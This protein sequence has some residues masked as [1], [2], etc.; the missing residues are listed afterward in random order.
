MLAIAS[1]RFDTGNALLGAER[2]QASRKGPGYVAQMFV[3]ESQIVAM[4]P[5]PPGSNATS[6]LAERKKCVE[7]NAID[8][9]V[10]RLQKPSVVLGECVGRGH[11]QGPPLLA[12][13][14][15]AR[16]EG[17]CLAVRRRRTSLSR[18]SA[19]ERRSPSCYRLTS[20]PTP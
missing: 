19:G 9:V 14:K 3:V 11:A 15:P 10:S 16:L 20:D 2:V 18:R 7:H 4:Q 6:S 1:L 8:A 17:R 5:S 12:S 13:N